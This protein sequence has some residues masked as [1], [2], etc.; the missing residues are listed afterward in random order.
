MTKKFVFK[1]TGEKEFTF[2]VPEPANVNSFFVF[3]LPKAGS[4]LLMRIMADVCNVLGIPVIDLPTRLFNLDIR[5]A[6]LTSDINS[7]WQN[8]GYAYVGFRLFFPQMTFDFSKTKN[9]LLVRDPRDMLVSYYFSM[10]YCLS[11]CSKAGGRRSFT[12]QATGG[13][14]KNYH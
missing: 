14:A 13:I 8:Q 12:C 4:T 3:S 5:P 11:C 1:T 6:E 10:R 7:L 9:I 2:S